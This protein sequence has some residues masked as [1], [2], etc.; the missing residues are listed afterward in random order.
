MI[1]RG[2]VSCQ[3][4]SMSITTV[5]N[6]SRVP[7]VDEIGFGAIYFCLVHDSDVYKSVSGVNCFYMYFEDDIGG[8]GFIVNGGEIVEGGVCLFSRKL[9]SLFYFFDFEV[10][11]TG[12][13]FGIKLGSS[14]GEF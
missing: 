10:G 12:E 8:D 9:D 2:V 11:V 14:D 4:S 1:S 13:L 6:T 5:G 3:R 7:G